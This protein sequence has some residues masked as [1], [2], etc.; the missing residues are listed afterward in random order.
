M[1]AR[2]MPEIHYISEKNKENRLNWALDKQEW[3]QNN[4]DC[5][6]FSDESLLSC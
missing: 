4:L 5:I 2:I 3:D 6:Y 1:V